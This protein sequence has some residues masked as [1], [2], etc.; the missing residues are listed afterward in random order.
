[1]IEHFSSETNKIIKES[2][3]PRAAIPPFHH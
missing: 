1:M 2:M 3:T